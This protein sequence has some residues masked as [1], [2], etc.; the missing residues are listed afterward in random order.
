[1]DAD[2]L[3]F[4]LEI[5]KWQKGDTFVPF[6]M[7]NKKKVSDFFIDRRF[8]ILQKEQAWLLLSGGEIAWIIGERSDDRFKIDSKTKKIMILEIK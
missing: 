2:K 3:T 6:G 1:L 7:K 8:S 4:P 5:R